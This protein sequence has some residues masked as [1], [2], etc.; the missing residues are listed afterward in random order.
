[1]SNLNDRERLPDFLLAEPITAAISEALRLAGG[2]ALELVASA[3]EQFSPAT[4]TWG[5]VWW[6]TIL[7]LTP[8]PG[9][10]LEQRRSA[11]LAKFAGQ[12]MPTKATIEAIGRTLTGHWSVVTEHFSEYMTELSFYGDAPGFLQMDFIALYDAV[13][14]V[15]PAHLLFYLTPVSWDSIEV[16]PLTWGET[17]ETFPTWWDMKNASPIIAQSVT[18]GGQLAVSVDAAYVPAVA[19]M[20]SVMQALEGLGFQLLPDDGTIYDYTIL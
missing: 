17:Q 18:G 7:N 16:M 4:A 20:E 6:E 10:T 15:I 13:N 11:V 12:V 9:A 14:T 2:Q 19:L 3:K 8:P 5:I 1:M